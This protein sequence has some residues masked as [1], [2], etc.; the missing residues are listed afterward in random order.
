MNLEQNMEETLLTKIE[1]I[2]FYFK[3]NRNKITAYNN[4]YKT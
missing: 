1:P 2:V 3:L 4:V